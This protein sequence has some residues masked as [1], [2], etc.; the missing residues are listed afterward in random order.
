MS[1]QPLDPAAEAPVS[2]K[3]A[4]RIGVRLLRAVLPVHWKTIALTL[5]SIVGVSTFTGALANSTKL[6]VD[7]VFGADQQGAALRVAL[8]IV[9]VAIG[10]SFFQYI[11]EVLRVVLQRSVS[12]T[13]Q[14]Q[15]FATTLRQELGFFG[16][17]HPAT[18]MVMVQ[19]LGQ[20]AGKVVVD[21]C[22]RMTVEIL[23]LV[24]LFMVMLLQDPLLTLFSCICVPPILWLISNLS[25]RMRNL[26]TT[27][28]GLAAMFFSVGSEVL[29]GI[30]TVKSYQ[31]ETKSVARFNTAME[32]M[33]ERALQFAKVTAATL[34][35]IEF[36]GGLVIGGFVVFASW[37]IAETDSTAGEFTAF[38]T[39]F[40]MAY[41]PAERLSGVWVELQKSLMFA[42]Q[43]YGQL[44]RIPREKPYGTKTLGD[45]APKVTLDQV[46]FS[47]GQDAPALRNVSLSIGAGE[48]IA[49]V[50]KS[51]AGK[52]TLIDILQRFYDPRE[53]QVTLGGIDLRELSREGLHDVVALISQDVFLFDGTL[54]ENIAHG[55]PG[56]SREDLERA[57]RIAQLDGLIA[58]LPDGLDSPV[59]PNGSNLSGGQRQRLSIA[60]G[61][62][63]RAKVYIFDEVTSALDGANERAVMEALVSEL[64]DATLLFV[65]HRASTLPY[66]DRVLVLS[67]GQVAG[68][69]R[70]DQL[71]QDCGPFQALFRAS[72]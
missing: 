70:A 28:A 68:F 37:Q 22:N 47:Y 8:I 54:A 20:S 15:L 42:R 46:S 11:T 56:A 60:R 55:H 36:L 2:T 44:D 53:G 65:T 72:V 30:K 34:P 24:S 33:E 39:A 66:V 59:G 7:D 50:G 4:V 49:V 6:V 69:D 61:V 48:R 14:K 16:N 31:L 43:M 62:A 18:Q 32:A 19:M 25:Q 21:V 17:Q 12:V 26:A 3:E 35:I 9:G 71:M 40:L 38:L 63:K 57:A 64:E 67:D 13:Y 5:L 41:K 51:G 58:R 1:E 27:D 23:I 52:S 29:R 45:A 10:K